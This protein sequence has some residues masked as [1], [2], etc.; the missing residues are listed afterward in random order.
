MYDNGKCFKLET[1]QKTD[2]RVYGIQMSARPS[3]M[4]DVVF[5]LFKND[6]F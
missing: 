5:F 6:S 4:E 3:E 2:W 1:K